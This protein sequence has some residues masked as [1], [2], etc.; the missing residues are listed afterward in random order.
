M[1]RFDD[2]Q[3]LFANKRTTLEQI[4]A[5]GWRPYRSSGGGWWFVRDNE[6]TRERDT[7][8]VPEWVHEL[9]RGAEEQGAEGVQNAIKHALGLKVGE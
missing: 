2:L 9:A 7:Q 3:P 5:A 8:F 6:E 1:A 4:K